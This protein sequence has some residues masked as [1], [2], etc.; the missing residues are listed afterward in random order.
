M[1]LES[2]RH[3]GVGV[4]VPAG[5]F[6]SVAD[7]QPRDAR[8]GRRSSIPR[9]SIKLSGAGYTGLDAAIQGGRAGR[10]ARLQASAIGY[11]D[12]GSAR[13]GDIAKSHVCRPE[14]R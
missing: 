6:A 11:W 1:K 5:S 13:M 8:S 14:S 10:V 4:N 3:I 7:D 9:V 2:E 12:G